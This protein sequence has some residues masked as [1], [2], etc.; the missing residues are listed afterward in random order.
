MLIKC[1]EHQNTKK[2]HDHEINPVDN[3]VYHMSKP[4]D[5]KRL[6]QVINKFLSC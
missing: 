3:V 2:C 6:S 5:K 1:I 4:I